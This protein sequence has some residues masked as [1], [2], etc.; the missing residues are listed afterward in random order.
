[1]G[2][3]IRPFFF[4]EHEVRA[5]LDGQGSPWF[6]AKD[7]CE[8][9]EVS[10]YRQAVDRLDED[11]RGGY[12]V[13][14]PGGPQEMLTVSESGLYS[15][16][17]T[18]RKPA[19]RAFRKWVTGTVLPAL[20]RGGRYEMPGRAGK[21]NPSLPIPPGLAV[22]Q[23]G[24][25]Q[26]GRIIL[27]QVALQV[28]KM[29]GDHTRL[30]DHYLTLCRTLAGTALPAGLGREMLAAEAWEEAAGQVEAWATERLE[31]REKNLVQCNRLYADFTAWCEARAE[32]PATLRKFGTVMQELHQRV[33]SNV[34]Y[35]RGV[36]LKEG[37]GGG[38]G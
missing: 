8:V 14:T 28:A 18:S 19:A 30:F 34:V 2:S 33:E 24:I 22:A 4:G 29:E 38:D 26:N 16:V 35:Y 9:L 6:V 32:A 25:R 7:V 37:S 17:F 13:P 27:A 12:I 5:F 1:M 31:P 11:E 15:L 10:D 3:D 21:D 20:R 36:A 23:M